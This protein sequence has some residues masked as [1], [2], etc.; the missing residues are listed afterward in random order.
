[1]RQ[2]NNGQF[3]HGELMSKRP[4]AMGYSG[5]PRKSAVACAMIGLGLS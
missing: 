3:S 4:E 1:M 2:E 5:M